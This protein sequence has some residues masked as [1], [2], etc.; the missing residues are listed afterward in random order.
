MERGNVLVIGNS[1]VG[2]STLINAV[3]GENCAITGYGTAGITKRLSIYE[4]PKIPFRIIDTVGFE[5]SLI[6]EFEAINAVKRWSKNSAKEGK[7]D[8]QINVIWFCVEGTSSKLFPKAIKD[9]SRATAMWPSVPIIVVIT[10]SYSIPDREKNREMVSNAFATQKRY[11]KNLKKVIPVVAAKY[12]LNESAY[13][14]PV[15]ITDLIDATNFLLPEG[16]KAAETDI[17]AFKLNRKRAFAHS[18]VCAATTS[19]V[20]VGAIP[21]P[22]SDAAILAPIE[23]AEVNALA[24][25]YGISKSESSKKFLNSLVEVGTVGLVA[26]Q[27]ISLLK[28]IPGINIGAAVLNAIIAGSIV[29]ALGEGS[30]YMFEQIHLGKKTVEDIDWAQK[31]MESEL[32]S[33][34]IEKVTAIIS[35]FSDKSDSK[36][37]SNAILDSFSA[38]GK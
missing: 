13:A 35:K 15:G 6:K 38:A 8:T 36:S 17:A 23:L 24:Q 37:I 11:S 3:L 5:P 10:K 18:I 30:I 26:K 29:A 14:P 34:F 16:I 28:A 9:L 22:F 20:I 4:S 7:E 31:V 19:G 32:S 12:E 21:I 27:A 25:I 1:G 33:Q 2:K